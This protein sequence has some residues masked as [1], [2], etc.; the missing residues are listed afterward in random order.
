MQ[1]SPLSLC[2]T[3]LLW[4]ILLAILWFCM[5]RQ[6]SRR[7]VQ[8]QISLQGQVDKLQVGTT[9]LLKTLQSEKQS[10]GDLTA[11]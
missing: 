8:P 1:T 9:C 11:A 2:F 6:L 4:P 10:A 3:P 7:Q 5:I